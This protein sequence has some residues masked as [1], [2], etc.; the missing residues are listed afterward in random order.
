MFF[1]VEGEKEIVLKQFYESSFGIY[2]DAKTGNYENLIPKAVKKI[3]LN[4]ILFFIKSSV[5]TG[6]DM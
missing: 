4:E 2:P 1:W 6:G 5:F 3:Q